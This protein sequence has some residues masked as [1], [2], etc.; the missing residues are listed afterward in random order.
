MS[1]QILK[2]IT[3]LFVVTPAILS[4]QQLVFTEQDAQSND[5]FWRCHVQPQ[6]VFENITD[7]INAHAL[8]SGINKGPINVSHNGQWYVFQSERFDQNIGG[9][10]AITIC[11][12]NFTAFEVPKDAQGNAFHAE[13]IMQITNNGS[14]I[15]FVSGGGTGARD[16]FRIDRQG[17]FW[18]QPVEL[19]TTATAFTYHTSPYLSYDETRLLFESAASS[20]PVEAIEEISTTGTNLSTR[21]LITDISNCSQVRS[22][23]FDI[24]GNI[25][26]EAETDAERIW[27][28]SGGNLPATAVAPSITNDNSPVTLPSGEIFSVYLPAQLHEPKVMDGNGGNSFMLSVSGYPFTEV[29][30]IGISAGADWLPLAVYETDLTAKQ[31]YLFP[32]PATNQFTIQISGIRNAEIITTVIDMYGNVVYEANATT[33]PASNLTP[34]LYVVVCRTN[35]QA[36][37]PV[38]ISI[39]N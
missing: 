33:I 31:P 34:G 21:L 11:S 32:N 27:K 2:I 35:K 29:Y 3:L 30:D 6:T 37:H 12:S 14:T 4:A 17:S 16:I 23:C 7:S 38:L 25:Y 13:G 20:Y 39:S 8:Y 24:S 36:F 10:E 5:V 26:V 9:Y 15:Y 28:L 18:S 19:T 1:R 22:P